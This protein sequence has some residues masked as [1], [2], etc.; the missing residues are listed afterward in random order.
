MKMIEK[1]RRYDTRLEKYI[2]NEI[3]AHILLLKYHA[4]IDTGVK[5]DPR[6]VLDA[7]VAMAGELAK[8]LTCR[9]LSSAMFVFGGENPGDTVY[10]FLR[11][12]AKEL[13]K[14][15]HIFLDIV[16]LNI[17]A[18][19]NLTEPLNFSDSSGKS[20]QILLKFI[21]EIIKIA[22]EIS[23]ALYAI[24]E[25]ID[26]LNH[27]Y[28]FEVSDKGRIIVY[29][30]TLYELIYSSR[31]IPEKANH[32]HFQIYPLDNQ[33]IKMSIPLKWL[34]YNL[35]KSRENCEKGKLPPDDKLF[36]FLNGK[37]S[38]IKGSISE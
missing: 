28:Q 16:L 19:M 22:Y 24:T 30:S 32:R 7:S 38:E 1:F 18:E 8:S 3:A 13:Y 9:E 4:K 31:F 5:L 20:P 26:R 10:N 11:R 27:D 34:N 21:Q 25:I 6:K 29:Y 12:K 23:E 37:I 17:T 35:I 36:D 33:I 15:E 2:K 14:K